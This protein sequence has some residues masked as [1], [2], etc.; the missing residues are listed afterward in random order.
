MIALHFHITVIPV[1]PSISVHSSG[2]PV[3]GEN[4][5][6][7]CSTARTDSFNFTSITYQWFNESSESWAHV[8]NQTNLT[9]N[10]LQLYHA[11]QYTCVVTLTHLTGN[12]SLNTS[13]DVRV[14][15]KSHQLL[16]K[17]HKKWDQPKWCLYNFIG[18]IYTG[19]SSH[20][21][22]A[23]DYRTRL[24]S[25]QALNCWGVTSWPEIIRIKIHVT[26]MSF[27]CMLAVLYAPKFDVQNRQPLDEKI[28]DQTG[29][30]SH[31]TCTSKAYSPL[32][33][34]WCKS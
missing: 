13:Q 25:A 21:L 29:A 31:T 15:S 30:T 32:T 4:Y 19:V 24:S 34:H 14:Q 10:P 22:T 33:K 3:V 12:L 18:Q 6:L 8:E 28:N 5:S 23:R 9:F 1:V 20:W 16:S 7:V 17:V 11:G 27:L 26:F 2:C